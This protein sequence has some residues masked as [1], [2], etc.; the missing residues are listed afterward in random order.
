MSMKNVSEVAG[1]PAEIRTERLP[2]M[3]LKRY[4]CA[5]QPDRCCCYWPPLSSYV[6]AS[7]PL[8][9]QPL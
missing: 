3:S 1:V 9:F 5:D 4:H 6:T 2:N 7:A 8:R